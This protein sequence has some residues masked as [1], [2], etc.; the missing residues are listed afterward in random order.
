MSISRAKG[1]NI[2]FFKFS[3]Q[4]LSETPLILRR[5]EQDITIHVHTPGRKVPVILVQTSNFTKSRPVAAQLF[6][7]DGQAEKQT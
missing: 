5:N 1:L 6:H 3:L 7:T 2:I 4:L